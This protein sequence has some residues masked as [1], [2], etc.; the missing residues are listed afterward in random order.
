MDSEIIYR[1]L[2]A[3]A[4]VGIGIGA[5]LLTNRLVLTRAASKFQNLDGYV[6]GIPAILYFTTP[7]CAPCKTIQRP[8]IQKVQQAIGAGIQVIEI[9]TSERVDLADE[10]GVLSVPTTFIIDKDGQPRQINHGVARAEKLFVQLKD[11]IN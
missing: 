10:W 2:Q 1:T 6:L 5:Y 3:L 7:T 4:I 11:W 8:A 9:D